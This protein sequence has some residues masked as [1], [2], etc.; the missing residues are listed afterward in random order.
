M[1]NRLL[2]GLIVS[3]N[4]AG[5]TVALSINIVNLFE[6][7]QLFSQVRYPTYTLKNWLWFS[8]FRSSH[9]RYC[10][11]LLCLKNN[12][13]CHWLHY[14]AFKF[15]A[16]MSFRTRISIQGEKIQWMLSLR[17]SN[18]RLWIFSFLWKVTLWSVVWRQACLPRLY[19]LAAGGTAVGTGLNTRV[20]FAE[21]V[22]AKVTSHL[23]VTPLSKLT[24]DLILYFKI[25]VQ[26]SV[27]TGT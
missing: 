4:V 15:F 18:L 3:R 19:M 14:W 23:T 11:K 25:T 8:R 24:Y 7:L 26:Y 21:K 20:G 22:A 9:C 5:H 13:F 6:L 16:Y 27:R 12:F 17:M 1:F 2:S 10:L